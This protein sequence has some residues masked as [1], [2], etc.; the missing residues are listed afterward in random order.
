MVIFQTLQLDRSGQYLDAA[1]D[2]LSENV[3]TVGLKSDS[4]THG[5]ACSHYLYL[6][7]LLTKKAGSFG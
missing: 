3:C 7:K 2:K 5:G 6:Y 4:V 1:S